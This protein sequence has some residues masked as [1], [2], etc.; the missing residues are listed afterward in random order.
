MN[1]D[2]AQKYK[3]FK[4]SSVSQDGID[5]VFYEIMYKEFPSWAWL[6]WPHE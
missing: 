1:W 5:Y 3:N 2:D 4:A 6:E